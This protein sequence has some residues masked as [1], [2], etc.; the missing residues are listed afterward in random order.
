MM[1]PGMTPETELDAL[2][3]GLPA[4][5]REPLK[6]AW[7]LAGSVAPE[8]SLGVAEAEVLRQDIL[9]GAQPS[10]RRF[11][12]KW[13]AAAAA[14]LLVAVALGWSGSTLVA[15]AG[16]TQLVTLRD[17]STVLLHPGSE[18]DMPGPLRRSAPV[19]LRGEARFDVVP[20]QRVF[21]VHTGDA[22]VTVLGTRF[23]VRAWPGEAGTAVHLEEGS[24]RLESA[25]AAERIE[26]GSSRRIQAGRILDAPEF[27]V[28]VA[29]DWTNGDFVFVDAPF[30]AVLQDIE[31]RFGVRIE[32]R[33]SEM[34]GRLVN[35]AFRGPASAEE[36]LGDLSL[37][38]ALT[39]SPTS[40]G[41]EVTDR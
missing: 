1:D 5:E 28:D 3:S 33:T 20:S 7:D 32:N 39:Y 2:L 14:V 23:V 37:M 35:G 24:V 16:N 40:D 21:R 26:A 9:A 8:P 30:S 11:P 29:L 31:R 13:G 4:A 18:L 15:P 19:H 22:R 17:G 27:G 41:F 34:Q 25:V 36:V 12:W 38:L 10:G 6:R